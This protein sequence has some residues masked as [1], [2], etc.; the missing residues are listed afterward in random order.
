MPQR[1]VAARSGAEPPFRDEDNVILN[2]MGL[3]ANDL[4]VGEAIYQMARE[5]GL[6][7]TLD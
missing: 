3:V 6:G 1:L 7:T 5:S 4:Q 2:P